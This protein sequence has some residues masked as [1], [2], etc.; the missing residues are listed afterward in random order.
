MIQGSKVILDDSV[1]APFYVGIQM[2]EVLNLELS[3]RDSR[4]DGFDFLVAPLKNPSLANYLGTVPKSGS[5]VGVFAESSDSHVC[6]QDMLLSSSEWSS[7]VI[8]AMADSLDLEHGVA[9][10]KGKTSAQIG[11]QVNWALHLSLPGLVLPPLKHGIECGNYARVVSDLSS[12]HPQLPM[13]IPLPLCAAND[14]DN[15]EGEQEASSSS[16]SSSPLLSE[17]AS[18]SSWHWWNKI[19]TL[20]DRHAALSVALNVG[21]RLPSDSAVERWLAEPI[22]ALLVPS[23][24]FLANKAGFPCLPRAHQRLLIAAFRH[25]VQVVLSGDDVRTHALGSRCYVDYLR[26]LYSN[27][28]VLTEKDAYEAP[29]YDFL[30]S[31]LQPLADNLESQT[32]ET[33]E[34]DPIK[35]REYEEAIFR[36]LSDRRSSDNKTPAAATRPSPVVVMVLGAGRGPLVKC[37][38]RAAKR[39]GDVPIK[40]YALDKNPNAVI[41]LRHMKRALG[42]T[43][44]QVEVVHCDMRSWQPPERADIIVSELLGSFGDNEL[45]PECLDGAQR[46]CYA[47]GG[48]SIPC[49][50]TS[51][52]AP[53]SCPKAW[54]DVRKYNS[55]K[56]FETSYVVKFHRATQL[57]AA[58]PCFTFV[59]PNPEFPEHDNSRAKRL[60]FVATEAAELHG[61]VG[62]FDATLYG[63]VHISIDPTT[64]SDQ[65]VSWFPIF[66]PLQQPVLVARGATIECHF[67]RCVDD[68]KVWY[69]WALTSPSISPIHNPNGR[70]YAIRLQ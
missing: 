5:S 41:T 27:K 34:K 69:E 53:I 25:N 1:K 37:A 20:C 49:A 46:L 51:T 55:R 28:Y 62:Y 43:D 33:F 3:L 24:V 38:L 29:Y 50:Y 31:P 14:N 21:E 70:S 23:S 44:L 16:S 57:A 48:I 47:D 67:W 54:N 59:H 30:Q 40:V 6:E 13:W 18:Q 61:F 4:N 58:Q 15:G 56:H 68:N 45:S 12:S 35:Y 52:L 11:K 17:D 7:Y 19:R 9:D 39:A 10:K 26:H 22:A 36:A 8:G 32:Y 60:R 66:F 2:S 64:F 42:W 63:D 65:M